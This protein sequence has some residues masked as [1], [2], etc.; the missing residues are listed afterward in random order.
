M[1]LLEG[2]NVFKDQLGKPLTRRINQNEVGPT[3]QWLEQVTG[4][5]L[6]SDLADDGLPAKWL[7]ST[8]RK[9]SSGDMDLAV[10]ANQV[11]KETLEGILQK[12]AVQAKQDPK[13]FV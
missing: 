9:P 6:T 7:G 8:G 12:W 11:N 5:D 3:V 2:G 4:L 10:D 1:R 13:D